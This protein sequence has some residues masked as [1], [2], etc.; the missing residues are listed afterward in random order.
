M[1]NKRVILPRHYQT[2]FATYGQLFVQNGVNIIFNSVCLELPWKD[3]ERAMSCVQ[4]GEYDLVLEWSPK[5]QMDLWELKDV[6]GRTECKIHTANFVRQL[7]GCIAP[8][9][10]FGHI[11]ADGVF[12]ILY[13]DSTRRL[14]H[15]ALKGETSVRIHIID[16]FVN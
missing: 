12:D 6:P 16:M 8:G 11:D 1:S 15:A 2:Q 9:Q 14:F 7:N 5:F 10:R 13:S 4:A 3:N